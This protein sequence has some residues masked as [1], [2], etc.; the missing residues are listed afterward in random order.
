MSSSIDRLFYVKDKGQ[1][2]G[3]FTKSIIDA[4]ML[5]QNLSQSVE[6]SENKDRGWTKREIAASAIPSIDKATKTA[7]TNKPN[8]AAQLKMVVIVC[9]ITAFVIFLI[10]LGSN[11]TE[12]SSRKNSSKRVSSSPSAP[13]TA[14]GSSFANNS[15][16]S[17]SKLPTQ[18]F[19]PSSTPTPSTY[20][21]FRPVT[22]TAP[23]TYPTDSYQSSAG[24]TYSYP[25]SQAYRLTPLQSAVTNNKQLVASKKSELT[26]LANEI[27]SERYS[28]N[29]SSQYSIDIFNS[30]VDRYNRLKDTY[31][32]CVNDY[33]SAINAF[34][35][36]LE[37]IGRR[38]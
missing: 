4:L 9:A 20:S 15:Y 22:Y 17:P 34:N 10:I 29:H 11:S 14:S 5:S 28:L 37:A 7:S 31:N 25:K 16:S 36:E 23:S 32:S 12:N 3:P 18:V 1:V 2:R 30:K 38:K 26:A 27:D 13:V 24:G 8:Y 19:T 6:I 35:R 21:S 33:N